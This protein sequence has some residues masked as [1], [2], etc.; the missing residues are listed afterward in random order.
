MIARPVLGQGLDTLAACDGRVVQSIAVETA[1]PEFRG[2]AGMWRKVAR[3]LGLHHHT[4]SE[5]VVRRFVSLDPQRACTE[6]RRAESERILR[7]QPYLAD[8][9][10]TTIRSGDSVRVNVSTVDEVPVVGG[11]RLRG[12][13]IAAASLGTI[14]FM[15][16]GMHVESRWETAR[17]QRQGFGGRISHP[18]LLGRPYSMIFDGQ[19]RPIGEYYVFALQHPFYTDLQR[20]A[21]HAGYATSKDFAW[22]RRPDRTQLIQPVDRASW[23]VGGVVRYGPPRRLGLVGA[24]IIGERLVTRNDFFEV[25]SASGRMVL[26]ADTTGARHYG[27]Y[28]VTNAAGVLGVRA[29]SYSRMRGLDAPNAQQ[30]V[31]TGTQFGIVF[32]MQPWANA[33]LKKSFGGLDAYVAGRS[34]RNFVAMRTDV[35]SRLDAETMRWTH[36]IGSGRAAWYFTPTT[37][38]TSELSS[39]FAGAWRTLMPFQL[40]LG[41]RQGGLRGYARSHEAGAQRLIGRLEQRAYVGRFRGNTAAVGAAAFTEAGKVWAG[42]AP[43]GL[44]TPVRASAGLAILA[45][46]PARSQRT[47]RAEIAVPFDRDHGARAEFRFSIREP[48]RGFFTEPP[49]IRSARIAA[50]PEHVFTWP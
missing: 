31:A 32:G 41:D 49:R 15:G 38:W 20:I 37:R 28:E 29:L 45:S 27:T 30:D 39:E 7:A 5:G 43:F 36:L 4:T 35:E 34:R 19:R 26:A 18:Q 3:K 8:A 25:D 13:K 46:I 16:T 22:L 11:A 21:W 10:V 6:F 1:K 14:N 23:N 47:I 2:A 33:P 50:A 12:G 42:D 24:M 40:E 44:E 9:T 48:A 17:G